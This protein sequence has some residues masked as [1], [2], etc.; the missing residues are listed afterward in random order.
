MKLYL[1]SYRFGNRP[2]ELTT[3]VGAGAKVA[4]I[5]NARDYQ[6]VQER[7][8]C[9]TDESRQLQE[10]GFTVAEL[11][12]RNYFDESQQLEHDLQG[13]DAVWVSGGNVFLLRSAMARSG[14]DT[15]LT[16]R[17]KDDS[18]IYAGYSAGGCVLS[19]SMA[20]LATVDD[21]SVTQQVYGVVAQYDGLGILEYVFVPHYQ[22]DHRESP[23]ID[24]VVARM[25]EAKE[26]YLAL[27]DGEVLMI[28]GDG[29][30]EKV[31]S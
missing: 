4:L 15:I 8:T 12:L 27:S 2:A 17:I 31:V 6:P 10:L 1:S 25:D 14:A 7:S 20:Q 24:E 30:S 28:D 11:D 19:P 5:A 26:S 18:L 3:F 9:V 29:T 13:C 16:R 21:P 23:L 22:S